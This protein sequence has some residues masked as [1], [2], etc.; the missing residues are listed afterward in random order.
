MGTTIADKVA[1]LGLTLPAP[2][3]PAGNFVPTVQ[4][5][6]TLHI[7]G[8]GPR[9]DGKVIHAG[10]VGVDLSV[11]QGRVAAEL[12]ALNLLAHLCAACD[13]ELSR[14]AR[15]VRLCGVVNSLPDFLDHGKVLN[16]ASDL[17]YAVLGE[18]GLHVRMA[19]G[20]VSLPLNFAVEIEASFE[21]AEPAP[22][23]A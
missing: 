12:C 5:G 6:R 18:K 16:G 1:S 20:A 11:E 4:V 14:V 9:I 15:A 13:G 17:L 7:A 8:Q 23:A 21:L 22:G 3:M 10:K 19:T 2:S